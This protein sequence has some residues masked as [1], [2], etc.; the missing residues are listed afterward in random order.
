MTAVPDIVEFLVQ[1]PPFD[2]FD[3]FDTFDAGAVERLAGAVEAGFHPAGAT[4]FPKGAEALE[5]LRVIRAGVAEGVD[6]HS[7]GLPVHRPHH[8][9]GDALATAQVFI[10]LATLSD[11]YRPQTG[12][13][14]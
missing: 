7:L 14:P 6:D 4:I 11:A 2:T 9:L 1:C 3:T 5:L 13:R 8:S 12:P 10:A